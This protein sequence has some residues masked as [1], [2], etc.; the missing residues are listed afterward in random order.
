M[1]NAKLIL[2]LVLALVMMSFAAC[3]S[4]SEKETEATVAEETT[5]AEI[6]ETTAA[7]TEETTEEIAANA[8]DNTDLYDD[9]DTSLKLY[10][11]VQAYAE[12]DEVQNQIASMSETYSNMGME[13]TVTGDD[14]KF[15]YNYTYL[16]LVNYEGLAENLAS[17]LESFTDTYTSLIDTIK[18]IVDEENPVVVIRYVDANGEEIYAQEFTAAE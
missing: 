15:I 4:N 16:E 11:T 3:G 18:L 12:S 14:N 1:R 13:L 6:E 2:C 5:A 8:D 10:D 7:E 17:S 9:D